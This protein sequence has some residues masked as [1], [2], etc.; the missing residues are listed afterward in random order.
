MIELPNVCTIKCYPCKMDTKAHVCSLYL[1]SYQSIPIPLVISIGE[2]EEPSCP[3]HPPMID[4]VW[5]ELSY[6]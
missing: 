3:L 4:Q 5:A 1:Q 6:R 2:Q